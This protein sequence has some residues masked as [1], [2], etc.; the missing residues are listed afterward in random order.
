M[1]QFW[2]FPSVNTWDSST[3]TFFLSLKGRFNCISCGFLTGVPGHRPGLVDPLC[4]PVSIWGWA[5]CLVLRCWLGSQRT[6]TL[7]EKLHQ[8]TGVCVS[9]CV[10]L[11]DPWLNLQHAQ[12]HLPDTV[13]WLCLRTKTSVNTKV[14]FP[15]PPPV[16]R[17]SWGVVTQPTAD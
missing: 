12:T 7:C 6:S 3:N 2:R 16:W 4:C 11:S 9:V 10:G 5:V 8:R 15:F 13:Q 14:H 17:S 1:L